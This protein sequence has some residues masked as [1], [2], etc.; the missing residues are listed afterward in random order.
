M[1]TI[2]VAITP[3]LATA[4]LTLDRPEKKNAL[5][6]H[7]RDE[8]TAALAELA[9][10]DADLERRPH[11]R[12]RRVLRRVRSRRVR[13]GRRGRRL[14]RG[15]LGEQRPVPPRAADVPAP[16]DRSRQRPGP[17]RRLRPRGLLRRAHRRRHRPLRPSG[18]HLR[19][20]RLRPA[21]R[22]R[23]RRGGPR[24]VPDRP[25]DRRRRGAAAAPG[26]R[27]RARAPSSTRRWPRSPL[28][29]P[30]RRAPC[31]CAP[32]RRRS[33]GP[34]SRSGRRSTSERA[35]CASRDRPSGYRA[36]IGPRSLLRIPVFIAAVA[37]PRRHARG[38]AAVGPRG[39]SSSFTNF[40][41][42]LFSSRS[43]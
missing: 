18:V 37:D 15:A 14:R 1:D 40:P 42:Q 24:P 43:W 28:A 12:G 32:R 11:R 35:R 4:T 31:C 10:D 17:R 38:A 25:A 8:V 41:V 34:A 29:S 36:R 27:G 6:A 9:D 23:R 13:P 39:R 16:A 33:P 30:P 22:A 3:E 7:L 5:S 2:T 26:H 20:R 21:P 19:R